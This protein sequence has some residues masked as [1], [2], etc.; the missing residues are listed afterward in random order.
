PAIDYTKYGDR[1]REHGTAL[2]PGDR[3][4][5]T[6]VK[7]KERHIEFQLGGGGYGTLWDEDGEVYAT[8]EGPSRREEELGKAIKA[9]KDPKVKAELEKERDGLRRE[10]E[11]QNELR[12]VLA[13]QASR[14]GRAATRSRALDAGSRF[15]IRFG[16]RVD[17][18]RVTP[19]SVMGAL[20]EYLEFPEES[21][22]AGAVATYGG[23]G[24]SGAVTG[25]VDG[26]RKGLGW[27]EVTALLGAPTGASER[28]E[29]GLTVISCR[30]ASED[31][32]VETEFVEGVLIRYRVESK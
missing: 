29:G 6:K 13:A 17:P 7:V 8:W 24:G 16:G 20:S 9:E 25:G 27:V 32:V 11:R 14:Q 3:V 21:F 18:A 30:F 28:Q 26:L 10:R 4:V 12:S 2:R 31:R 5:V 15:N 23:G 19:K 1:L 22:G